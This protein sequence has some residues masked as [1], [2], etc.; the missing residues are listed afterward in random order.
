MASFMIFHGLLYDVDPSLPS[1]S[2]LVISSLLLFLLRPHVHQF[3]PNVAR[4]LPSTAM[5]RITLPFD[6]ILRFRAFFRED[7]LQQDILD[8]ELLIWI[9]VIG[10]SG[11]QRDGIVVRSFRSWSGWCDGRPLVG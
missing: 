5:E 11:C 10:D 2:G 1:P 6:Q 8:L 9:M 4:G 3:F 7:P